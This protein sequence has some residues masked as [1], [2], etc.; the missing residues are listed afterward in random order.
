ME[1]FDDKTNHCTKYQEPAL[2]GA[3]KRFHT[4][5]ETRDQ[6]RTDHAGPAHPVGALVHFRVVIQQ[7]QQRFGQNTLE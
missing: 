2:D 7:S 6:I 4:L 3:C 5:V 1:P